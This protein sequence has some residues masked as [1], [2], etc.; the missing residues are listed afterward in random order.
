[1]NMEKYPSNEG[2]LENLI[3]SHQN[4]Q[5][6][7]DES[8]KRVLAMMANIQK[9]GEQE[10][11]N[12]DFNTAVNSPKT[13]RQ[14]S[15]VDNANYWDLT[16]KLPSRG[17]VYPE[18]TMIEARPLKVI[19]VKKLASITGENADYVI[20][21][22][23]KRCVRVQGIAGTE[24]IYLADKIY[25]IL[26]MRAVTYRDSSYTVGFTCP[27]CEKSSNY[28]FEVKNLDVNYL[29]DE[30]N[31]DT[32]IELESGEYIGLRHLKI[33]DEMEIERFVKI[34]QK[35]LGEIDVELLALACMITN[36]NGDIS[37]RLLDK[38]NYVLEFTPGDLS[39]VTTY[40]EKYS[41]GIEEKMTVECSECG[42]FVPMDVVFRSD[43]FL[44]K[45]TAR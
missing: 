21:D 28:H 40:I 24:E 38:Y 37:K 42:G 5:D 2:N 25:L 7:G 35:V 15:E 17:L 26:W 34:N 32:K 6:S 33:K 30:Y 39:Q 22:I 8:E 3:N 11:A 44:P 19:E 18:G 9:R 12:P 45:Y 29:K 16:D 4:S 41:I 43:F 13:I 31:P 20:N 27:K 36:I 1:M 14:D 10:V 23:V